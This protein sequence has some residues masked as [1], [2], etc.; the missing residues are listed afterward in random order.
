MENEKKYQEAIERARQILNTPYT[1][2]W[3]KM[4]ELIEHIFPELRENKDE[5]IRKWLI[6]YL[7]SLDETHSS[8][9][10]SANIEPALIWLEKQK[11]VEWNE[12]DERMISSITEI[13]E[14]E[15]LRCK[16][17]D[18]NVV[19][20]KDY[21]DEINWLK[22]LR[23]VKNWRP[24]AEQMRVLSRFRSVGVPDV[25]GNDLVLFDELFKKLCEL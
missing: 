19:Y 24:T 20:E 10:I 2:G 6:H 4:K 16:S 5:K 3:D 14:S 7:M 18:G 22:S 12:D 8:I 9:E 1:A 13:L 25:R 17:E 15:S 21:I 23:P 11:P